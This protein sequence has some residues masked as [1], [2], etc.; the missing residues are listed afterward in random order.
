[1]PTTTP[2]PASTRGAFDVQRVRRDFP[3]LSQTAN[4]HPL[5]YLD[6]GATTQKPRQVI[7]AQSGF[8]E[9]TN[10]NIHRG[11]YELSQT[12]TNLYEAARGKVQAF[13]NA[14][15][16][17]EI[18]FTRGTTESI[19]LVAAS[20]GRAFLK[21]G[22]EVVISALEH[23][24][25]I[26]PWQ[27]IC[28]TTGAKL[29]VIPIDDTGTLRMDEY[30]K[31][32]SSRTKFVALNH[33]SNALGTVNPVEEIIAKAHAVGA[34]VLIDG[35]QHVAHFKTDVRA[36]DADFYAFSSH[37]LYG[38]TGVGVL[39]GKRALLDAMPPYQGGGDMIASV[40]FEKTV[41]AELPNKFEAGTPNIA[42]VIGLGAAIDYLQSVGI[43]AAGA[44]EA[45]LL[46]RATE[47]ISKIQGVRLIGTAARKASVLSFIVTDPPMSALDIGTRLDLTGIAVRTGHHCCQPIMDRFGIPG[48]ARASFAMYN[49]FEE[50]DA[51]VA[52]LR[53]IVEHARTKSPVQTATANL[54]YPAASAASPAAAAKEI[55]EIFD[56]FDT[57]QD[58]YQQIIEFGEKL[59]PMP[60]S[61]KT[62]EHFVK[63][64]QSIVH[65]AARK[66]PRTTDVLE[67]L[68]DS[69]ADLVRGLIAMLQKI[70]SGQRG[71][72]VLA[73]DA[74]AFFT[75]LGL[76]EHLSMTRRN[77]LSAMIQRIRALAASMATER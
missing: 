43:D 53:K 15:E 57:W 24:S 32:L 77:G 76:D 19:N 9:T 26:V 13:L 14:A 54:T 4:G 29:R 33:V 5:I 37:K 73:F 18:I 51:F 63:G 2:I 49:T 65:I 75:K 41:Y 30:A 66:K 38:P 22:D 68:A 62:P 3:I 39:Y 35:A 74:A 46:R 72:D 61:L 56:F 55:A 21:S 48:T 52:A 42:G 8:Y 64:C 69:D 40:T 70:Y 59:P 20:W 60:D 71:A 10:S 47:G 17:A 67:F 7:D 58:R 34:K 16:P 23:H 45:A 25:N 50:V 27:M 44:H 11:V 28:E 36:L 1:M 6:N 31:L 12:A